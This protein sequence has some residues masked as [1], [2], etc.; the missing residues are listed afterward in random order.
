MTRWL[1]VL[2]ALAGVFAVFFAIL[3]FTRGSSPDPATIMA[4]LASGL[5]LASRPRKRRAT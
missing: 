3:P 5:L 2:S 4:V 1:K